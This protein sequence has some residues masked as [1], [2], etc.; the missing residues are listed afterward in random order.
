MNKCFTILA[1]TIVVPSLVFGYEA[2]TQDSAGKIIGTW[3]SL[4]NVN[5]EPQA[6][7]TIKRSGKELE[8]HFVFRGLTVKG[9]ENV[10]L[11]LPI[12]DVT[13]DGTTFSLR[14][15]FPETEKMVVTDW[16][17]KLRNDNE[18]SFVMIKE[19]GKAVEDAPSFVMKRAKTN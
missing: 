12:T 14:V 6:V 8:G 18:A 11:D 10:T 9:K 5:D 3:K 1:L 16:E 4:D 17:L 2:R 13:F 15:T 7:I 19:D